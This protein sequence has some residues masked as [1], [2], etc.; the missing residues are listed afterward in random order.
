MALSATLASAD[1][2]YRKLA[3]VRKQT[4]TPAGGAFEHGEMQPVSGGGT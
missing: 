4:R 3:R 1:R 2:R